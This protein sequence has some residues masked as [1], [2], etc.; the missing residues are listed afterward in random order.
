MKLQIQPKNSKLCGQTCVAMIVDKSLNWTVTNLFNNKRSGTS[1]KDL[2]V[3][4]EKV[5]IKVKDVVRCNHQTI[6]PVLSICRIHFN[7]VKNHSHYCIIVKNNDKRGY[8]KYV[9]H[10]IYDPAGFK[11][12]DFLK[13]SYPT[14][15]MEIVK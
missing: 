9:K 14:S 8:N 7:K 11:T 4:L 1:F 6:F 2:H 12:T 15:F 10:F 13:G 3:A 5:S